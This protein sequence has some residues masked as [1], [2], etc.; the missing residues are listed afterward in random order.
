MKNSHRQ[1]IKDLEARLGRPFRAG[2][3]ASAMAAHVEGTE[4]EPV[5]LADCSKDPPLYDIPPEPPCSV[6]LGFFGDS[7]RSTFLKIGIARNVANRMTQHIHSSPM[8][9]TVA[10]S[11]E[12]PDRRAAMAVEAA[13]LR[14][15][16]DDRARGEWVNC[17]ASLE[18]C[19]AIA[20]S[21]AEVAAAVSGQPVEFKDA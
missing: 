18:A 13:L 15:M 9:C 19:R 4:F 8:V 7:E 2:E 14:H 10:M 11:A 5:P 12:F 20:A 17:R 16:R 1:F 3:L 6:Y 21:L